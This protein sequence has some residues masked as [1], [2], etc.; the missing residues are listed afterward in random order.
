VPGWLT[1]PARINGA[2]PGLF[3]RL[4]AWFG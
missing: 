3:H 1:V 4:A 2:L